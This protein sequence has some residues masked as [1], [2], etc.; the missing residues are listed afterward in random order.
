MSDHLKVVPLRDGP[1]CDVPADIPAMLRRMADRI[2]AGEFGEV[3][4][5]LAV[6][7]QEQ[8]YPK[9]FGWGINDGAYDPIIQFE[10]AR[11]W[12]VK[13]AAGMMDR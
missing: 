9:T 11:E 5:L 7:P 2:E 4:S 13:A 8:D 10:L 6:M 1:Q 3:V 12:H